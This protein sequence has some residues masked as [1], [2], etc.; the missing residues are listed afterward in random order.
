[1]GGGLLRTS[2]DDPDLPETTVFISV[3]AARGRFFRQ[4]AAASRVRSARRDA[5]EPQAHGDRGGLG[6]RLD[7]ELGQDVRDMDSRRAV[8]D[9]QFVR[10][11]SVRI[12]L[13]NQG[14]HLTLALGESERIR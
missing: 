13:R 12:A 5:V 3:D 6:P 7:L 14:E 9:E 11:P 4:P 2:S 8:A 10:D 1:M